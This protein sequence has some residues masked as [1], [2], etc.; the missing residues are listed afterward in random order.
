MTSQLDLFAETKMKQLA[1]VKMLLIFLPLFGF[2]QV[3]SNDI[4]VYFDAGNFVNKSTTTGHIYEYGVQ[5]YYDSVE[6]SIALVYDE[7]DTINGYPYLEIIGD[8]LKAITYVMNKY[9]E[10]LKLLWAVE[11]ILSYQRLDGTIT[12]WRKWTEAVNKYL[13][14]K[15][16]Q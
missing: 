1:K 13:K 3:D 7:N 2:G 15:G 6:Y 12:N 11:D 14:L 5:E 10:S 16:K 8:T 4:H 9:D